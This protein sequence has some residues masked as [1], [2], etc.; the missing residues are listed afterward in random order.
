MSGEERQ[1]KKKGEAERRSRQYIA[2]EIERERDHRDLKGDREGKR[3]KKRK[4][5]R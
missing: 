3:D 4:R 1:I 5:E 2:K